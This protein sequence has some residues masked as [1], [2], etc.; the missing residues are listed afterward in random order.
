MARHGVCVCVC[1]CVESSG[2]R[3]KWMHAIF[4]RKQVE[5][6]LEA[7]DCERFVSPLHGSRD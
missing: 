2:E 3:S 7:L 4:L 5:Q 1:V 6:L